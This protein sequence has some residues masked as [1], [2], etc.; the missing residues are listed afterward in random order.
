MSPPYGERQTTRHW[1]QI[2]LALGKRWGRAGGQR[3]PPQRAAR[4]HA[5]EMP[6]DFAQNGI[7]PAAVVGLGGA[8]EAGRAGR[9]QGASPNYAHAWAAQTSCASVALSLDLSRRS[10]SDMSMRPCR[11][12]GGRVPTVQPGRRCR[13]LF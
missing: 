1:A 7:E 13:R 9:K 12:V 10:V 5:A 4:A 6:S 3:S 8:R 11:R 2:L